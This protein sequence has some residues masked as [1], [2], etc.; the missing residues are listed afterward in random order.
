MISNLLSTGE[1]AEGRGFGGTDQ[2]T[3]YA[4]L[5]DPEQ[6]TLGSRQSELVHRTE[7]PLLVFPF[8]TQQVVVVVVEMGR[9]KLCLCAALCWCGLQESGAPFYIRTAIYIY[10]TVSACRNKAI[11]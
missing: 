6:C 10:K 11:Y 2:M 8:Q 7:P 3:N 4:I 9:V 5:S 1:E